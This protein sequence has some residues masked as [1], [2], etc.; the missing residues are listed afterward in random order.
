VDPVLHRSTR[1]RVVVLVV[2]GIGIGGYLYR[3]LF[4]RYFV[5]IYAYTVEDWP[6]TLWPGGCERTH[7]P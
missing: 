5:P 1:L 3:V 6:R 7:A 4:A 2:G